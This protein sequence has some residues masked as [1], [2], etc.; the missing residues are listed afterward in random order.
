MRAHYVWNGGLVGTPFDVYQYEKTVI[1]LW[2]KL[3]A[4]YMA[5]EATSK[6]FLVTS[7]NKYKFI[8]SRPIMKQ[9]Y[10]LQKI[11]SSLAQHD[12]MVYFLFFFHCETVKVIWCIIIGSLYS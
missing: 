8:E 9:Y 7:F 5:L 3:K 12:I 11:F 1:E 6:K 2:G 4:K 10:E